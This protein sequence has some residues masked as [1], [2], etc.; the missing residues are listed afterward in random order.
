MTESIQTYAL[1]PVSIPFSP[2]LA[3]ELGSNAALVL[4]QI[5]YWIEKGAGRVID[6]TRWIY[7]TLDD[8]LEQFPW[9]NKWSLRKTMGVL[10]ERG[11]VKFNQFEKKQW[12]RRGWYTIDYEVLETLP[13]SKC[14]NNAHVEVRDRHTSY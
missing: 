7:N 11:L 9:L 14:A 5:H 2:V 8:W 4:Q 3:V 12:K 13:L 6:G 10:R 1:D